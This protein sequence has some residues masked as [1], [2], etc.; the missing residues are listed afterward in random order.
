MDPIK[1]ITRATK[2]MAREFKTKVY[3][4]NYGYK[5]YAREQ[6][7]KIQERIEKQKNIHTT[8]EDVEF[9]LKNQ[10]ILK[11]LYENIKD[12][13]ERKRLVEI[14]LENNTTKHMECQRK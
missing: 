4:F 7:K 11:D 5:Q 14:M 2:F 3:I 9:N 13:D 6:V 1:T 10:I 8:K 12:E